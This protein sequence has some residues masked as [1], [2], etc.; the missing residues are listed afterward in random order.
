MEADHIQEI[1]NI[2]L[3]ISKTK[4]SHDEFV[5]NLEA[6]Y[7]EKLIIE[8]DKYLRLEEKLERTRN[9]YEKRLFD[10]DVAKQ[11]SENTITNTFLE[12]LKEKNDQLE[13]VINNRS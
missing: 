4:A 8:Y 12:Q 9:M 1:N 2:N 5:Q 10:L 6:N 3:D 11:T 7:N 13:E